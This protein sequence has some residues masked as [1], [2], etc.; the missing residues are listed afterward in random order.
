MI[1][2]INNKKDFSNGAIGRLKAFADNNC[3]V[4]EVANGE[5]VASFTYPLHGLHAEHVKELNYVLIKPNDLDEPHVFE[6]IGADRDYIK[7]IITVRA[8]S[9][10]TVSQNDFVDEVRIVEMNAQQAM[11]EIQKNLVLANGL[12]YTSDMTDKRATMEPIV[13]RSAISCLFDE[14]HS[15]TSAFGGELKRNQNELRLMGRRG[16]DNVAVIRYGKH[17][18]GF[19]LDTDFT[20]TVT[21][22][23]PFFMYKEKE[24]K[25]E[26]QTGADTTETTSQKNTVGNVTTTTTITIRKREGHE[27]G[28]TTTVSVR[29]K[30]ADKRYRTETTR[31]VRYEDGRESVTTSTTNSDADSYNKV[32]NVTTD[33]KAPKKP[34]KKEEPIAVYGDVVY[35]QLAEHYPRYFVRLVDFSSFDDVVDLDSLNAR[36]SMYFSDNK[37]VDKPKVNVSVDMLLSPR[38]RTPTQYLEEVGLF[39][40]VTVYVK[41]YDVNVVLKV[42]EVEYD[43]FNERVRKLVLG[44]S[45]GNF[46]DAVVSATKAEIKKNQTVVAD[47]VDAMI[48]QEVVERNKKL[49][50]ESDKI[51]AKVDD[52]IARNKVLI[53]ESEKRTNQSVDTKI[54]NAKKDINTSVTTMIGDF[55]IT[56]R[57]EN[58]FSFD[59]MEKQGDKVIV[60]GLSREVKARPV[61]D[62]NT[63]FMEKHFRRGEQFLLKGT[64]VINNIHTNEVTFKVSFWGVQGGLAAWVDKFY[65]IKMSIGQLKY[66]FEFDLD[67]TK[68]ELDGLPLE[69]ASKVIFE[70]Q[71]PRGY[72]VTFEEL[73]LYKKTGANLIVDGGITARHIQSKAIEATHIRSSSVLTDVLKA[74]A[75]SLK[76]L[77]SNTAHVRKLFAETAFV[78]QLEATDFTAKRINSTVGFIGGFKIGDKYLEST[79]RNSGIGNGWGGGTGQGGPQ[80][81]AVWSGWRPETLHILRANHANFEVDRDGRVHV[82]SGQIGG[83]HVLYEHRPH[84]GGY[85]LGFNPEN[86]STINANGTWNGAKWGMSTQETHAFFAG[87]SNFRITGDGSLY[88]HWALFEH[89]GKKVFI[90]PK[91]DS[92]AGLM[93]QAGNG[94]AEYFPVSNQIRRIN[95]HYSSGYNWL[96]LHTSSIYGQYNYWVQQTGVS[97]ARMKTDIQP[98]NG[99]ALETISRVGCFSYAYKADGVTDNIGFIAQ[100]LQAIDKRLVAERPDG[101]LTV[102]TDRLVPY[103]TKGIQQLLEHI[104]TLG[105]RLEQQEA[106]IANMALEMKQ[107]GE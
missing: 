45:K 38:H 55:L 43:F 93:F 90:N 101:I 76:E 67:W 29:T 57:N 56:P 62:E 2:V 40:T 77:F 14:E 42:T 17:I 33:P 8:V 87:S 5:L 35:S 78:T 51:T 66:D 83:L 69:N 49:K 18:K 39:D 25:E 75:A 103:L 7:G 107:K 104:N 20:D 63:L 26:P 28:R 59:G 16:R 94:A 27:V 13:R 36:A 86:E 68:L 65:K 60:R 96:A 91:E 23:V 58:Y 72:G 4:R 105:K 22:V 44:D 19:T 12:N 53:N 47:T 82:T 97:D 102:N 89:G 37:D 52:A 70:V 80:Q 106:I 54:S 9:H 61:S 100:N 85:G 92:S 21:V 46:V 31:T 88:G 41:K 50:E 71:N 95:T 99:D 48:K 84:G 3:F 32:S 73:G 11:A 74:D 1:P 79:D 10:T 64:L 30:I 98:Y 24:Q 34:R 6:I 81:Y 15:I